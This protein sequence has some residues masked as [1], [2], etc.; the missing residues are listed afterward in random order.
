MTIGGE[1]F[2]ATYETDPVGYA[3]SIAIRARSQPGQNYPEQN[4]LIHDSLYYGYEAY[5][6]QNP[7]LFQS[8]GLITYSTLDPAYGTVSD[9]PTD[10]LTN[11]SRTQ[12]TTLEK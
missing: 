10:I 2:L 11:I 1:F 5:D 3:D 9:T 8:R 6:Y 7:N 4:Y 12:N